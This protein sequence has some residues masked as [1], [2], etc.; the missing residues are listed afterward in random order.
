MD[1]RSHLKQR[2][3]RRSYGLFRPSIVGVTP[4]LLALFQ[5]GARRVN[6]QIVCLPLIGG[7]IHPLLTCRHNAHVMLDHFLSARRGNGATH[8]HWESRIYNYARALT[9]NNG[10]AGSI[11]RLTKTYKAIELDL[12]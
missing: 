8:G 3:Q 5:I 9:G 6:G 11:G 1:G 12:V 7:G 10:V 4:H 2:L